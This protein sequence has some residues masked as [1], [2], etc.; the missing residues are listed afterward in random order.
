LRKPVKMFTSKLISKQELI[1]VL[2]FLNQDYD[3]FCTQENGQNYN[4]ARVGDVQEV[5]FPKFRASEPIKTFLLPAKDDLSI[6]DRKPLA[7]FGLKGCDLNALKVLDYVYLQGDFKDPYYEKRRNN[8]FIF[9]SDCTSF[10][11]SCFCTSLGYSPYPEEGFDLNLAGLDEN[12][13]VLE[14]ATE[15]AKVFLKEK[16]LSFDD[17]DSLKRKQLE[18][19]RKEIVN[20]VKENA[21]RYLDQSLKDRLRKVVT[22]NYE[23]DLWER[24]AARCVECGACTAVC[25][26]C[27]CFFLITK[28]NSLDKLRAW[29]SCLLKSYALVAGGANPRGKL[30]ERL[31]NRFIK[32]FD[33]FPEV[34]NTFGCTGC[35]RCVD[36]CIGNIDIRKILTELAENKVKA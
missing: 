1:R 29:D 2:D 22:E 24:E 11:D 34:L 3:L 18:D 14:I 23:S 16:G 12:E 30:Y 35:G 28:N 6:S 5:E 15:K 20:Q 26:S 19:K 4:I 17:I 36:A 8:L 33:F 31:R 27:H 13:Y 25:S 9:S 7:V 21:D 10:K 32:K